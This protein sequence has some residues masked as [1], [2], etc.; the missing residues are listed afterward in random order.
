[1]SSG[2]AEILA[3]MPNAR[4]SLATKRR[5][6]ERERERER[7]SVTVL[8]LKLAKREYISCYL[9]RNPFGLK[10]VFSSRLDF[11][12]DISCCALALQQKADK[13]V[14]RSL[15]LSLSLS[16]CFCLA[17]FADS[18]APRL[19]R[20]LYILLPGAYLIRYIVSPWR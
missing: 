19:K 4:D 15:S 9:S 11:K 17:L 2:C 5:Q 12:F 20:L 3:P 7:T 16:I 18:P 6:R 10:T 13:V 8:S 14:V 1:M